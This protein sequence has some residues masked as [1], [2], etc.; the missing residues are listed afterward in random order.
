[1]CEL[2]GLSSNQPATVSLSIGALASHGSVA[3]TLKDGWGVAYCEGP[4]VRLIKDAEP[5][6][7][8]D[9]L[10]FI[11]EHSLRS[12]IVMA[13]VRTATIGRRAYRNTQP[14]V[15][16]LAGRMHVFAHNGWLP[17]IF[18]GRA[19]ASAQFNP[20]GDTDSEKAFCGL[21]EQIKCVWLRAGTIP[22]LEERLSIVAAF[23]MALRTLGPANFLYSDGDALFAHGHRRMQAATSKVEPPGLVYLQRAC[24]HTEHPA[25]V[26]GLSIHSPDQS[27][28]LV[29]SVPLNDEPWI[30]LREGEVIAMRNG[31]LIA[32]RVAHHTEN[33]EQISR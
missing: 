17:H 32:R 3:G 7:E 22:P 16:E 10:R 24:P 14:F 20:V 2:L 6:G 19:F 21:L 28:A 29:A 18:D 13:H 15:R 11:R 12:N 25:T 4:D 9:W 27:V 31:E 33:S 23:A 26:S 1:M 5:A 30:P 8:S